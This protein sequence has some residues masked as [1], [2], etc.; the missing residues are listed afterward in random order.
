MIFGNAK[1]Q[2][3]VTT[4]ESLPSRL[5]SQLE[6][7]PFPNS[8]PIDIADRD[9]S[10]V[11]Y[12]PVS[13][14]LCVSAFGYEGAT[15]ESN[16]PVLSSQ[17]VLFDRDEFN[18]VGHDIVAVAK[19]LRSES[20]D[21]SEA[22]IRQFLGEKGSI[23]QRSEFI[24]VA[25]RFDEEFLAGSTSQVLSGPNAH[26]Y[27]DRYDHAISFVRLLFSL[28]PAE[29]L[30][31]VSFSTACAD[32]SDNV[33]DYVLVDSAERDT[34]PQDGT[35]FDRLRGGDEEAEIHL[36]MSRAAEGEYFGAT[37]KSL[38][39]LLH[40]DPWYDISW[41]DK[42]EI[43]LRYLEATVAGRAVSPVDCSEKLQQMKETTERV[44]SIA[45]TGRFF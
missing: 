2:G 4:S 25:Q 36:D 42:R 21:H 43:L 7:D 20:D 6:L 32:P 44:E 28:L 38:A 19:Y 16:R 13:D 35:V 22:G 18:A 14:S 41:A 45:E 12:T 33:E 30:S 9:Y 11:K 34:R 29:R 15:D 39:E 5:Q 31:R 8:T 1:Y 23:L 24:K 27:Y 10:G 26:I 37:R 3:P 17:F 40:G